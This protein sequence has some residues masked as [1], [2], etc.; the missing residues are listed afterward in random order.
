[1]LESQ[2][3]LPSAYQVGDI[4]DV[5]F[6]KENKLQQVTVCAVKFT[7]Y[8][9]VLYDIALT[10]DP[11]ESDEPYQELDHTKVY[12]VDSFFVKLSVVKYFK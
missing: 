10:L 1:M 3:K 5:N 11:E 6:S 2:I 4:V 12:D 8:G 9:K 7:S